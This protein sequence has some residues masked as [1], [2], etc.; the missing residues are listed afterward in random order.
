MISYHQKNNTLEIFYID[1]NKKISSYKLKLSKNDLFVWKYSKEKTKYLSWDNK[2]LKKQ[3]T[4]KLDKFRIIEII[5]N[6]DPEI[7]SKITSHYIPEIWAVDIEV[8]SSNGFPNISTASE[9]IISISLVNEKFE[10]FLWTDKNIETNDIFL[11][12]EKIA[13]HLN[14]IIN[15]D[16]IKI[17]HFYFANELDMLISFLKFIKENCE[18]ITGWNMYG[19]D[20]IYLYNRLKNFYNIDIFKF[21]NTEAKKFSSNEIKHDVLIP[22]N[23]LI[24]D[25]LIVFKR[26][27]TTVKVKESF[28]LN[29]ISKEIL[30][31]GK[32]NTNGNINNLYKNLY[33]EFLS[34]NIIDSLLVIL[35]QK[36]TKLIDIMLFLVN[37]TRSTYYKISPLNFSENLFC[38]YSLK[39]NKH[40]ASNE[41]NFKEKEQETFTGGYIKEINHCI[42]DYISTF[43]FSSQY[44]SIIRQFNISPDV[45]IKKVEKEE[46]INTFKSFLR[47]NNIDY[48]QCI[49][50]TF[51][52]KEKGILP[53]ILEDLI[54]LRKLY[55]NLYESTVSIIKKKNNNL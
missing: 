14:G 11:I 41:S 54:S 52:K 53:Y 22:I 1:E 10:I 43:D 27:D 23:K 32:L 28:S 17:K 7:K 34:Y 6:L 44:P 42:I 9:K 25:L 36:K 46:T 48:V 50:N 49:N 39:F 21:L 33:I 12:K 29:N 35:I 8:D 4:K 19:F 24:I 20:W 55:K 47:E 18:L 16:D 15:K 26:W 51:Y 13:S 40:I 30:K 45:F 37:F 38:I 5:E 3:K 31:I 2:F